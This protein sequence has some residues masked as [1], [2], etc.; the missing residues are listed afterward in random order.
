MA[1]HPDRAEVRVFSGTMRDLFRDFTLD[2][3][4]GLI[5]ENARPPRKEYPHAAPHP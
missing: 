3:T 1:D 4:T 2:K 5:Q